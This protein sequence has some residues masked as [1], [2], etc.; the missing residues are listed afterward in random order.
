MAVTRT[1]RIEPGGVLL[2]AS[3][4]DFILHEVTASGIN[5]LFSL[6]DSSSQRVLLTINSPAAGE[7]RSRQWPLPADPVNVTTVHTLGLSFLGAIKY[8]WKATLHSS[9]IQQVVADVDYESTNPE[10]AQF[11]SLAVTTF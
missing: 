6:V 3:A 2:H 8:T 4:G 10:Q 5:P 1:A 9:G 7:T 11:D